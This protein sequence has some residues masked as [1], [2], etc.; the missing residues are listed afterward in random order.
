MIVFFFFETFLFTNV[1]KNKVFDFIY[2]EHLTIFS[3]RPVKKLCD[4]HNL[5]IIDV[6]RVKTKGGSIRFYIKKKIKKK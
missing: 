4:I 6:K 2:H 1:I 5:Q 3:L